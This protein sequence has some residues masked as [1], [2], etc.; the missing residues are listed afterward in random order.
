[1]LRFVLGMA[2]LT[3]ERVGAV[4]SAC[5]AVTPPAVSSRRPRA[6]PSTFAM[7]PWVCCR[8]PSAASPEHPRVLAPG[9]GTWP[10][11][12]ANEPFRSIGWA[13]SSVGCP[14]YRAR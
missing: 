2:E 9:G 4:L 11:Q 14:A 13:R 6:L 1:M 8:T 12:L 7:Q 5:T 3:G 10:R